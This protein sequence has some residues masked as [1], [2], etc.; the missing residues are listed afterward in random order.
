MH[1]HTLTHTHIMDTNMCTHMDWSRICWTHTLVMHA[2]DARTGC[3]HTAQTHTCHTTDTAHTHTHTHWSCIHWTRWP[4]LHIMDTAMCTHT[5]ACW[6]CI[7]ASF[8]LGEN[9]FFT[10][11]WLMQMIQRIVTFAGEVVTQISKQTVLKCFH[12]TIDMGILS[13]Y[14]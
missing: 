14:H 10:D 6:C 5:Y 12:V 8:C 7:S 11:V 13:L 3:T 2:V 9:H 4:H 1:I